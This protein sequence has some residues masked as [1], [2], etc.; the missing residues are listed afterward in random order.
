VPPARQLS[1]WE[2]GAG[3]KGRSERLAETIDTLRSKYG[4]KAVRRASLADEE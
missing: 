4:S 1:L 2:A 3:A